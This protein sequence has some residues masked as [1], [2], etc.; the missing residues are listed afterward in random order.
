MFFYQNENAFQKE[1]IRIVHYFDLFCPSH[2]HMDF[3][4][5]IPLGGSM[6]LVVDGQKQI[7]REGK[8]ALIFSNQI[9]SM[10]SPEHSETIVVNFST[11]YVGSFMRHINGKIGTFNVFDSSEVLTKYLISE[12]LGRKEAISTFSIKATCYAICSAFLQQVPLVDSKKNSNSAICQI[13]NYVSEN[14]H[15]NINLNIIAKELGYDSNYI[16]R[17]FHQ[18]IDIDFRQFVNQYRI[19]HAC[20]LLQENVLRIS[21]IALECG[22]QTLRSFNRSFVDQIGITPSEYRSHKKEHLNEQSH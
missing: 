16:S 1:H 6:E 3:E 17:L 12:Y 14:Y 11:D 10:A 15:E 22:F 18:F 4:F 19:D 7:L 2:L 13:L 5:I 9:H 20:H 21:E 8:L